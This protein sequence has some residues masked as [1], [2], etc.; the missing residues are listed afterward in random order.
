VAVRRLL[1]VLLV[2]GVMTGGNPASGAVAHS[3]VVSSDPADFTPHVEG[4]GGSGAAVLALAQGG[5]T[6]YAGGTFQGVSNAHG[7]RRLQRENLMAFDSTTGAITGLAVDIDGP[8]WALQPVG[9]WLYVGGDF[10]RVDGVARRG[11]VRVDATTGA[12]DQ[13]FDA[14]LNGRVTEIRLVGSRLLV[15]GSFSQRLL[16]L[17]PQ[18]G[19]DTGYVGVRIAGTVGTRGRGE[20]Y[21]FAVDAAGT[22]LV[23][24][25]NF[26]TVAGRMR[27]QAFMLDLGRRS[28]TLNPWQYPALANAC[29]N[30]RPPD[31][32]RDVDFSP[33]GSYFVV[34]STGGLPRPSG[35]GR[36]LCDATARFQTD[37][38]APRRPFWVNYTGGDTLH[39][40][41][42]TGAA[43][44]A[45]G[46]QRRF[47]APV[48]SGGV[49]LR[50][51]PVARSG[52]GALHPRTG[53]ALAWNPGKTRGI[54]GKDFLATR[55]GLWVGSDG[56]EF[57]G[58]HHGGIAFCPR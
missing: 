52:I 40:V 4:G 14:R 2:A 50:V 53:R 27:R 46:H 13:G 32:L 45:Q 44:Y 35:L 21:R 6:T 20:V 58:E 1:L 12:V 54:G 57:A 41:A 28:A 49:R 33:D 31:Y 23:A 9:R 39:S 17:D 48:F 37:V 25:G 18:T 29:R 34:V 16:A 15:G 7:T 26:R 47:N 30:G 51:A 5:G 43:V 11:I 24:I 38:A 22:H 19:A 10:G 36:D 56:T 8:V 3:S 55:A 42:A